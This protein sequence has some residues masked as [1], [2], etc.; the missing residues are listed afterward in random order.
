MSDPLACGAQMGFRQSIQTLKSRSLSISSV[1]GGLGLSWIT[2]IVELNTCK[3]I[4]KKILKNGK[5]EKK[6]ILTC[7]FYPTVSSIQLIVKLLGKKK[8]NKLRNV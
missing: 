5:K 3:K 6:K 7:V 1:L 8:I 2:S 4:K